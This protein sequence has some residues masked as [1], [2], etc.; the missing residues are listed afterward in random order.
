MSCPW[1]T[2]SMDPAANLLARIGLA[3]GRRMS[4]ARDAAGVF[5]RDQGKPPAERRCSKALMCLQASNVRCARL[6]SL[7]LLSMKPRM[8]S[9]G[10]HVF[11]VRGCTDDFRS[12]P[13]NRHSRSPSACLKCGKYR[14]FRVVGLDLV[15]S[16]I[17]DCGCPGRT[18]WNWTA[19]LIDHPPDEVEYPSSPNNALMNMDG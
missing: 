1:S 6:A 18:P 11:V 16:S 7:A 5:A 17:Y 8:C 9:I 14:K 15:A 4:G 12:T 10:H 2:A 19:S 13:I 3:M